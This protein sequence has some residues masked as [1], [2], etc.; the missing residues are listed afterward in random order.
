MAAATGASTAELPTDK[1]RYLMG[2]GTPEDFVAAT[3][4][5]VDLFDCVTPTRHGRN[6]QAFTR[7]GRLNL[8]NARFA[9]DPG[10]LDAECRCYTCRTFSRGYLR[11]LAVA[12]EMLAAVALSIHNIHYFQGMMAAIRRE[13]EEARAPPQSREGNEGGRPR[14]M[15]RG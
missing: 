2:V 8:R 14:E 6:N 10:P 5:G 11:H 12:G 3:R 4:L 1:V 9:Q 15:T 13:A 7:D